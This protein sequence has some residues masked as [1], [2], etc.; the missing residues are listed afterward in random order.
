[1]KLI[2]LVAVAVI[3]AFT[4]QNSAHGPE[5]HLH[6][7]FYTPAL[8]E[9]FSLFIDNVLKQVPSTDFFAH[10]DKMPGI[11]FVPTDSDVYEQLLPEINALTPRFSL[12]YKMASL[13]NQKSVLS[14]Q[15]QELLADKKSIDGCVEI[16]GPGTYTS[17]IKKFIT[18]TGDIYAIN[19]KQ[20]ASDRIKAFSFNIKNGFL[21]YNHFVPLQDY[22]SIAEEVIP[23]NSVDLVICAIGLHHIPVE[24]L[25]DFVA[26]IHRILRPGG[27]FIVRDHDVIN[28]DI[29]D[30]THAAHSVYNLLMVNEPLEN[31]RAEFRNFKA[32]SYWIEL[33]QQHGFEV[34]SERLLQK[35][36]PTHN[37]MLKFT[38]IAQTEPEKV[39]QI[40]HDISKEPGYQAK[41]IDTFLKTTEWFNVDMT[42][43]YAKFIDY[44]PFY[45]FPWFESVGLYWDL[46]AKSWKV[47]AKK[48][49]HWAV[50]S[51]TETGMNLFIGVTMTLEYVAKG[52]ISWPI[53][54][55]IAGVAPDKIT[56]FIND[57]DNNVE[58][59]DSRIKIAQQYA[60]S[61]LK[62]IDTPRYKEFLD[63]LV[64]LKKSNITI[65]EIAGNKEI[66]IKVRKK[67]SIPMN[68]TIQGTAILYD[69][70][71]PTQQ[72][73]TYY[74][75]SVQV[76][77]LLD[78][79]RDFSAHG[80]E[81]LYVHD[82]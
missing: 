21:P 24:K 20:E 79:M 68:L 52:I 5:S 53:R 23:S 74:A 72:D 67:N 76:D 28:D 66:Q 57:R 49:S 38:K 11:G 26:S 46:F 48:T 51:S 22:A 80:I 43:E 82:F 47:A 14:G 69:W 75:L 9:Q 61:S 12:Y 25:S 70:Q 29:M 37:T 18:V 45:E 78:V 55:A 13:Q 42:Q 36:D 39:L 32:L 44:R 1:M 16:G 40:S 58:S 41:F 4:L 62:V 50:L 60:N 64:E 33:L 77:K 34:G 59:F 54:M 35:G 65:L 8:R 71:I 15:I 2:K 56:L 7:V 19:D 30:L 63:I 27:T 17:C 81:V 3:M 31:E 73:Y 10:I 6:N